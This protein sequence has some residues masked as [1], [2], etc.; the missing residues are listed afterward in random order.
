MNRGFDE[1]LKETG[2]NKHIKNPKNLELCLYHDL[3]I[4]GDVAESYIE[5]LGEKYDVNTEKFVFENYF[6]LEFYGDSIILS[7]VYTFFPLLR[8][9]KDFKTDYIRFPIS[10]FKKAIA[11]GVLE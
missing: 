3:N 10:L 7:W 8:K 4:Y 11:E 6:P 5:L 9:N 2:L 1:F